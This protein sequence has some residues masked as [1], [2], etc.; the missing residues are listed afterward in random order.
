MICENCKQRPA[1][2]TVTHTKNGEEYAEH[3]CN[4]CSEE[5]GYSKETTEAT[6]S[7]SIAQ[8]FSSWFGVPDWST[9]A[10]LSTN[11]SQSASQCQSCNMTYEQFLQQGKF[12]CPHCYDAFSE[13]LPQ[14]F[15]R[16]HNGATKHIGKV[17]S[18][19]KESY[20]L[21]K[22]IENLRQ[23]MK[24]AIQEENFE[25]AAIL[26]D[27]IYSLQAKLQQGGADKDEL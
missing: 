12:N 14:I 23:K 2:V 5:I 13:Q 4:V 21:K 27:K 16:I 8:I 10:P 15:K 25:D 1:T 22:E 26:R 18:G 19:L 20:Q 11:S 6:Q 7:M 9:D 24:E 17:P 3:Y